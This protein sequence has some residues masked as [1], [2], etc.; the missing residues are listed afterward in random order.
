MN[1]KK[2]VLGMSGGV[3]SSTSVYLLQEQGYE[4]IGVTLNHKKE[5]SLKAEIEA[6][7]RV[8]KFFEIKHIVIDIE[9][10]FQKQVVEFLKQHNIYYIKVWGGG[11]QRSGIPDLIICLKGRFMAIELKTDIRKSI[12]IAVIQHR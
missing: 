8:A 11:Y 4:V 12:G 10:I 9:D 2:V 5:E 7:Q 1:R 3:D 6:A